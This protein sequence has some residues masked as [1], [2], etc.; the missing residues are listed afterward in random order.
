MSG[1]LLSIEGLE[2]TFPSPH[3]PVRALRGVDLAIGPGECLGIV[4]E[5]GSGKSLTAFA[6]MGLMP[7]NARA[8]AGRVIFEGR[9]P[10]LC[11]SAAWSACAAARL[12]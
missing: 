1:K 3:G 4:G 12:A 8:T 5:S 11:P 10:W 7:P 9:D 6:A 2:V